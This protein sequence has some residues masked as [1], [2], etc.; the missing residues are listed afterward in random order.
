[1]KDGKFCFRLRHY[2][3]YYSSCDKDGAMK[4]LSSL[5]ESYLRPLD[6]LNPFCSLLPNG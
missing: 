1:M 6:L 2:K 3:R 5:D 4:K